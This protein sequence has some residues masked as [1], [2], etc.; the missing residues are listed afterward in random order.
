MNL[1][2]RI[3]GPQITSGLSNSPRK[4]D[5]NCSGAVWSQSVT[6]HVVPAHTVVVKVMDHG[7]GQQRGKD[8]SGLGVL[9]K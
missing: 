2:Y 9:E 4:I 3:S 8:A 5:A 1:V 6:T 7:G